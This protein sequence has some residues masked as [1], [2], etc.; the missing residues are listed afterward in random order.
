VVSVDGVID[1]L[2]VGEFDQAD[3]GERFVGVQITLHN[4][5]T[6]PYSDSPS[7][8]ATLLSSDDEQAESEIVTGG[9]CANGFASDVKIAPGDSQQGCVA[10]E[11]PDGE[12]PATFQFTLDSGFADDT[13][14]WSL[15]GAG[16]SDGAVSPADTTGQ[17]TV[18]QETTTREQA[19][20]GAAHTQ[21]SAGPLQAL[22][23]YWSAINDGDYSAAY[24]RLAP[25][26]AQSKP[27]FVAGERSSQVN[28]ASF[29]GHVVSDDG[30][31]ATIDVDSLVTH[32]HADECTSWRG[33][34]DLS[35]Q[36]GGWLIA[37][38][39][40]VPSSCG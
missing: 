7:N 11:L 16:S 39:A 1:P 37:K 20:V 32:E 8:G 38:A 17:P 2:A 4:V 30:S 33:S 15:A 3:P 23:S 27:E 36:G 22:E 6:V 40:I 29:S 26:V 14:Q 25:G 5:G 12:S 21:S 18:S 34:Y 35:E 28:S 24:G 10:F 31:S 13:G 19:A 9:P